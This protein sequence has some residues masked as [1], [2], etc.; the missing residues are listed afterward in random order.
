[1]SDEDLFG[2][3]DIE[4]AHDNPFYKEDGTYVC[5]ITGVSKKISKKGNRGLE[6][7]YTIQEGP[8][9]TKKIREWKPLPFAWNVKGFA[10]QA[11]MDNDINYDEEIA[12]NA[13]RDLSYLKMRMKEYG[14]PSD[15]LNQLSS[16]KLLAVGPLA[17]TIKNQEGNE[18]VTGVK[19]WDENAEDP[20]S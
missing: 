8:K 6:I 9:K 4:S 19:L 13:A 14:F 16:D 12:E 20:F 17:V 7:V 15:N 2:D 10:T 18:R 1:M 5:L 11:D 3:L